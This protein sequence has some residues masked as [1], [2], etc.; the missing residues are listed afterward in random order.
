MMLN[1]SCMIAFLFVAFE[2]NYAAYYVAN[3]L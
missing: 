2:N 1:V 3:N